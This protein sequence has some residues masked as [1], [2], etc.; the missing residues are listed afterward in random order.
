MTP[1]QCRMARAGLGIRGHD[2]SKL[3]GISMNT[4]SGFERDEKRPHKQTID[5]LKAAFLATNRVRFEKEDGVFV[6]SGS[7]DKEENSI[8][9]A[10]G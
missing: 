4:I 10:S 6:T 1:K 9:N 8:E 7:F 2:L 5:A 3:S